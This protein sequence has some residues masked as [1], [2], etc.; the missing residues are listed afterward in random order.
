M[1]VRPSPV[2]CMRRAA[3]ILGAVLSLVAPA[4]AQEKPVKTMIASASGDRQVRQFFGQ[5]VASQTVDLAFQVGG[6]IVE[7]PVLEGAPVAKGALIAQL[8]LEPFQRRL[9]QARLQKAQADRTVERLRKLS[10]A[11]VS[12]VSLDDAVTA[13]DLA[14]DRL[15]AAVSASES[16]E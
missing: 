7:Y 12:Q 14:A 10:E 2:L 4:L 6:Q 16:T 9:E 1:P 5:I 8:D 11:A 15:I 3:L 13:A